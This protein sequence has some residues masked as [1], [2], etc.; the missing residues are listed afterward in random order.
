MPYSAKNPLYGLPS[1]SA[2]HH[3]A[4]G[5]GGPITVTNQPLTT[6]NQPAARTG[7]YRPF[8]GISTWGHA[9]VLNKPATCPPTQRD[10]LGP[11]IPRRPQRPPHATGGPDQRARP[12]GLA[13]RGSQCTSGMS[14][15]RML[16]AEHYLRGIPLTLGLE[17][18]APGFEPGKVKTNGFTARLLWPLGHT[19]S[20]NAFN[21][22]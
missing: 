16:N 9:E 11:P 5:F 22:L 8:P 4:A 14:Q 21:L 19:P 20:W 10:C 18:G 12:P 3:P 13:T 7:L 2:R 17:L 1:R 15:T 6:A